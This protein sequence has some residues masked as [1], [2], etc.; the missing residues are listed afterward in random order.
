MK[1]VYFLLDGRKVNH[2]ISFYRF[3]CIGGPLL[4]IVRV[5]VLDIVT[6]QLHELL[7]DSDLC[8]LMS[9]LRLL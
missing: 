7:I 8:A 9:L 3:E 5:A 4:N 1:V 2:L 6:F